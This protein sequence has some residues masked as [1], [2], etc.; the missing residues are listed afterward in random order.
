MKNLKKTLIVSLAGLMSLF[1]F[2]D[3]VKAQR[4]TFTVTPHVRTHLETR[5]EYPV[6][7]CFPIKD[8]NISNIRLDLHLQCPDGGCSDWDY[9]INVV[10]RSHKDGKQTDYQLGRMITPYSGWYNRGDN[11]DKWDHIWSWNITEY[12]PLLL[13]TVEIVM[14]YE[15]YQDGFLATT[16]FIFTENTQN[17]KNDNRFLGVE[18][19]YYSYYPFGR[20][21]STIDEFLGT[22]KVILPKGTKKVLSRLQ[23]SGHGGDTLNAAAEFLKKSFVYV[24]NENVVLDTAVWRD[25]C[26]CNPIQPQGG[27]WIYKRAGWCPGTKVQEHYMDL[28]PFVKGN[29]LDV[30]MLF[31]YYNNQGLGEPGYQIANELFFIG[32]KNYKH[33]DIKLISG[34]KYGAGK[35]RMAKEVRQTNYLP[36]NFNLVFKTNKMADDKYSVL[37]GQERQRKEDNNVINEICYEK[38]L[39]ERSQTS[40]NTKYIQKVSLKDGAYMIRIEDDGCDGFSWWANPDQG[41]GYAMIYNEDMTQVL[42]TFEPDFGCVMEYEFLTTDNSDMI[43]HS[44]ERL[45]TMFDQQKDEFH[46]V[47]F[48]RYDEQTTMEVKIINRRTKA[49]VFTKTFDKKNVFDEVISTKDLENGFYVAQ[50]KCGD[51]ASGQYFIKR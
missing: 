45:T 5:T 46:I 24:A 28:T 47:F 1:G 2:N 39:Y 9:S 11:A 19:I 16:D 6:K 14:Q 17:K 40:P 12:Y 27:T 18:Q 31:E 49:E 50:I 13:D 20:E 38:K 41:E 43:K 26:G 22:K 15:G 33:K 4:E 10:L 48:N 21:D 29:E 36:K 30:K 25:D 37:Q 34:D 51:Y 7:A 3:S 23:I 8:K 42:E 35:D 32:D 44:S